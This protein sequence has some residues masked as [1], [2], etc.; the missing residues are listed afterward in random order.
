MTL[1]RRMNNFY[2]VIGR[3]EWMGKVYPKNQGIREVQ[4]GEGG[5]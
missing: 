3:K 4:D 1:E 5:S 2:K